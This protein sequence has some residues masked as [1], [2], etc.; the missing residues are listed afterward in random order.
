MCWAA[1]ATTAGSVLQ[2]GLSLRF[3][4]SWRLNHPG[5]GMQLW[6]SR[7]L[8]SLEFTVSSTV[9]TVR[10][11]LPEI[12]WPA[13]L[14]L[15]AIKLQCKSKLM[16]S[17]LLTPR[18][19]SV[20]P[21]WAPSSLLCPTAASLGLPS[22]PYWDTPTWGSLKGGCSLL[23]DPQCSSVFNNRFSLKMVSGLCLLGHTVCP[24]GHRG[25]T[26]APR[27][28]CWRGGQDFERGHRCLLPTSQPH[29]LLTSYLARVAVFLAALSLRNCPTFVDFLKLLLSLSSWN[30]MFLF[31]FSNP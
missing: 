13:C 31:F 3:Q 30:K 12:A 14:R 1:S 7:A 22:P 27:P 25:V 23:L 4:D 16:N 5:G 21:G 10:L 15:R 28:V 20:C 24:D 9:V 6:I 29:P 8:Q 19:F 2:E 18:C 11:V 26:V 17:A